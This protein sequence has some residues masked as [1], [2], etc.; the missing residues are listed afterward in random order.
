MAPFW[1]DLNPAFGG[2]LY[3][4]TVGDGTDNWIVA[5]WENVRN[6]DTADTHTFEVWIRLPGG[7]GGSGA[8]SEQISM[9][10]G[11]N[12]AQDPDNPPGDSNWGAENRDGSSGISLSAYPGNGVSRAVHM[13][14]PTPGGSVSIPFDIT[15]KKPGTYHSDASLTSSTTPG[16][17]QAVQTL[18][19]TP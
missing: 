15:S 9:E 4:A 14:A 19:V 10:Y 17:T 16:I 13:G 18:T 8:G 5:D 1:T 3:V 12:G 7:T 2:A 11:A 6:Y